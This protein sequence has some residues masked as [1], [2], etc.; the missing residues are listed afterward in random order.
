MTTAQST[1][2]YEVLPSIPDLGKVMRNIVV[3]MSP[4]GG[5]DHVA[6]KDP[7]SR[8]EVRGVT[9]DVDNLAAYSR[10]TGLR[11]GNDLPPTYLFV[12]G[13]PLTMEL[14]SRPDFPFAPVG[15]VHVANVIT[16]KRAPR[17]DETFTA[18]A[19]AENLRPHRKGLLIDIVTEFFVEGEG[20]LGEPVWSQTATML[21]QGTS[22]AKNAPVSLTTRG[23]DDARMLPKPETPEVAANA[24][25]KWTRDNVRA[26]VDASGDSNPIHTSNLG[27][28]AFGFPSV[29]AHGMYSAASVLQL[30]EGRLGG[31]LRYSVEFHKPVVIPARV[32]AWALPGSAGDGCSTSIQLRSASKPE[33]LHLNAE[34]T[35]L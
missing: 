26:Y 34:V 5:T 7:Q 9:V 3:G 18:R 24:Q 33:K 10:A 23:L 21:S 31:A 22:F 19:H 32:A 1:A 27:A 4:V 11:L 6:D 30:L 20:P 17:V 16:Q 25:W 12:I 14:M 13:F 2:R 35:Q 28:K 29:I 8:L 15:A